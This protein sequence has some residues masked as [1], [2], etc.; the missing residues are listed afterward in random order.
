MRPGPR[1][2]NAV[3]RFRVLDSW[4]GVCALFVA[5]YHLNV[6]SDIY[7]L[8]LVRNAYL[9]VDFFFV[10]SGFVITHSYADRLGTVQEVAA[11][12]IRRFARIWPLHAV[13]LLAFIAAECLKAALASRGQLIPESA[14]FSGA[15]SVSSIFTNVFLVQSLG[16]EHQLTWN[17]PSWSISAEFFTYIIFAAVVF[18]GKKIFRPR[19]FAPEV[20]LVFLVAL[21]VML[22]VSFAKHDIDATFDLGLFRC[23]YG[24]GIGHL[25]FLLWRRVL[26]IDRSFW[27]LPRGSLEFAVVAIV[28]LFVS[29]VGG[30]RYAFVAPLVFA[31]A[32]L[33]FAAEK[34]AV[35]RLMQSDAVEWLGRI[36][37]SIYM[38]HALVIYHLIHP[39]IKIIEKVMG[40]ALTANEIMSV[41]PLSG[42][43]TKLIV[44]G[45]RTQADL[46]TLLYL[47]VLL[48]IATFSYQFIELPGQEYFGNFARRAR[49]PTVAQHPETA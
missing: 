28:I 22:L 45:S 10:L 46:L 41:G 23:L 3:S 11:F 40:H 48:G 32:V 13:V 9:F 6:L 26:Q 21:S 33:T 20:L 31:T 8:G 25:T 27:G 30:T 35:S 1:A 29:F 37:Y 39:G 4:R 15:T 34:G 44:L 12:T 19:S 47:G 24:F 2:D 17:K 16:I 7:S 42:E 14:P 36:S 38:L 5:L 43:A 18:A 49:S